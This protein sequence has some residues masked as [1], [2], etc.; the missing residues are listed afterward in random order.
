MTL[1]HTPKRSGNI[2][3]HKN[4]Y[5]NVYSSIIHTRQKVEIAKC[6]PSDEWVNKMWSIPAVKY[7][8]IIKGHKVPMHATMWSNLDHLNA[9]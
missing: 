3:P 6:P 2:C 4:I 9:K 8:S 5:T 1:R 7:C